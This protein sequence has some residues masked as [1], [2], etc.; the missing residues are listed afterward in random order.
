MCSNIKVFTRDVIETKLNLPFLSTIPYRYGQNIVVGQQLP[1][2]L[3]RN[4]KLGIYLSNW[5]FSFKDNWI[6]NARMETID[7][8]PMF[9]NAYPLVVPISEFNESVW[10]KSDTPLYAAALWRV[11]GSGK[12]KR[13]ETVL[14]TKQA[15]NP[16]K[17][18]KERQLCF[19]SNINV[20]LQSKVII[21]ERRANFTAEFNGSEIDLSISEPSQLTLPF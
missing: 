16:I 10:F 17:L 2:V 4:N 15:E 13:T 3:S 11:V 9:K 12:N 21:P 6:A 8:K 20:W 18:F 5:G 7:E 1:V 14:L 19:V